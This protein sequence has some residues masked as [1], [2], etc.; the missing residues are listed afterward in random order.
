MLALKAMLFPLSLLLLG[1]DNA[2]RATLPGEIC[3]SFV[4]TFHVATA[5]TDKASKRID[6]WVDKANALF[7]A[8][9]ISFQIVDTRVLPM[10][11]RTLETIRERRSLRRFLKSKTINVFVVDEFLDPNP[12]ESTKKAASWQGF[13]PS[14]RLSGAHI[15]VKN[16]V[17]NTYIVLSRTGNDITLAHELGHFF[18][19]GHAA[20]KNN[21]MSYGRKRTQFSDRQFSV[22]RSR[23]K[24]H[25]RNRTLR[26]AKC[27]TD[28]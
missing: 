10:S 7:G 13:K 20:D 16:R 28:D 25:K 9:E 2:S 8:A 4:L 15:K 19:S 27:P 1:N 24:K 6:D 22:F 14:G 17:P 21:I 5:H 11:Y 26:T 12:S 3:P 18:G 23:A